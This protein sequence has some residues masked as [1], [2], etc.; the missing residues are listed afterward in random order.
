MKGASVRVTVSPAMEIV[1]G[2]I[3]SNDAV[4]Y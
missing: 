4:F 3:V 2:N 1:V